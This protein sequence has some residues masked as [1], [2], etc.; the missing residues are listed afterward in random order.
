MATISEK[1]GR[2]AG[3][4]TDKTQ[5]DI[6]PARGLGSRQRTSTIDLL[7]QTPGLNVGLHDGADRKE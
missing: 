5:A 1:A 3:L 2:A 6:S 7:S 4:S